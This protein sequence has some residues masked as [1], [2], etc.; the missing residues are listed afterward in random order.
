MIIRITA[1]IV[2]GQYRVPSAGL[3]SCRFDHDT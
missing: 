3:K 2:I 1:D